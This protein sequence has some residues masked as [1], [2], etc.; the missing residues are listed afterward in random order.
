MHKL[1]MAT[2][3]AAIM[4]VP[5]AT[6]VRAEDTTVI[7]RNDDGDKTV[8]KKRDELHVLPVPRV[9]EKKTVIK[10]ERDD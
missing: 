3:A 9:E 2:M 1:I 4:I 7:K 8:V 6:A 5:V 10:K